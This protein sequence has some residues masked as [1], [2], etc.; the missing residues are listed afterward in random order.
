MN[1]NLSWGLSPEPEYIF[2]D[3]PVEIYDVIMFKR[4]KNGTNGFKPGQLYLVKAV[5][6]NR[7]QTYLDSAGS[8]DNGW[9]LEYFQKVKTIH[10]SQAIKGDTIMCVDGEVTLP[11]LQDKVHKGEVKTCQKTSSFM[12]WSDIGTTL[13]NGKNGWLVIRRVNNTNNKD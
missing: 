2:D 12:Y 8:T 11:N 6:T 4:N 10:G 1:P 3:T 9:L 13:N 7:F 5:N